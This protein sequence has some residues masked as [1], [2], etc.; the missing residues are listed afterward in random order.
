MKLKILAKKSNYYDDYDRFS[1]DELIEKLVTESLKEMTDRH[2]H[3]E[4]NRKPSSSTEIRGV[5]S[6]EPM[7][8]SPNRKRIRMQV[9]E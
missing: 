5:T 8:D 9:L 7:E 2:H 4:S 6:T 1:A 3:D